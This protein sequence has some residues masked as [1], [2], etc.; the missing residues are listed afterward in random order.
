MKKFLLDYGLAW[1]GYED[2]TENKNKF[3]IE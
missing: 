2:A 1:K 3:D